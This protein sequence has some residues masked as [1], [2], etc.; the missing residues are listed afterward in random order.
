MEPAI[1]QPFEELCVFR[2][3]SS[4]S[5]LKFA[6]CGLWAAVFFPAAD[7]MF[8]TAVFLLFSK[9]LK[10]HLSFDIH[11]HILRGCWTMNDDVDINS[12]HTHLYTTVNCISMLQWRPTS[13]QFNDRSGRSTAAPQQK[14]IWLWTGCLLGKPCN[15]NCRVLLGSVILYLA[16]R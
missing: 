11:Q 4:F 5:C 9:E 2:S 1:K 10:L 7:E 8:Q 15:F 14:P 12:A 3:C 16:Y 13:L 6:S